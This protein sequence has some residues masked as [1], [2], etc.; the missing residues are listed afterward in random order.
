M[1]HL[2]VVLWWILIIGMH[3]RSD[4]PVILWNV[5]FSY[6][7]DLAACDGAGAMLVGCWSI[8]SSPNN[9]SVLA[10][11][12][13]G[14]TCC[15]K[16]SR[17]SRILRQVILNDGCAGWVEDF[18]CYIFKCSVYWE[19][20]ALNL[21]SRRWL[22][23]DHWRLHVLRERANTCSLI[24]EVSFGRCSLYSVNWLLSKHF[25][26][27]RVPIAP[28]IRL[29]HLCHIRAAVARHAHLLRTAN[30]HALASISKI[31]GIDV[32]VFVIQMNAGAVRACRC[33]ATPNTL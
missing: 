18:V 6:R 23:H 26:Y 31:G 13:H 32:L 21:G 29:C 8:L 27:L 14:R 11:R 22:V 9:M 12:M 20:A 24:H 15:S 3:T 4:A 25:W 28:E 30:V 10:L 7:D 5:A 17:R 2:V 19:A 1:W 33:A 16:H